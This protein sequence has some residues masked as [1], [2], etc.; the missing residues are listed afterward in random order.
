MQL[1]RMPVAKVKAHGWNEGFRAEMKVY[2]RNEDFKVKMM[3]EDRN[4]G[5]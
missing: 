3:S 5:L 4:D 2:D 1:K